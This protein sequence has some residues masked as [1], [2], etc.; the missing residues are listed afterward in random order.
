MHSAKT[1]ADMY[2]RDEGIAE[3]YSEAFRLF[4]RAAAQGETGASIK[5]GIVGVISAQAYCV[6]VDKSPFHSLS[7]NACLQ[8]T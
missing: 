4:Q 8:Q 2:L 1:M 5:L 6:T 7:D 3:N